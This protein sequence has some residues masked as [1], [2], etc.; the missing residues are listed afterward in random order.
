MVF[1]YHCYLQMRSSGQEAQTPAQGDICQWQT[2]SQGQL[3][4]QTFRKTC[5]NVEHQ[6]PDKNEVTIDGIT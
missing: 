4:W 5:G 6:T 1:I 3:A 2:A